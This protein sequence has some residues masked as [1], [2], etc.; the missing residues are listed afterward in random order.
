MSD[1]TALFLLWPELQEPPEPSV[2]DPYV[3]KTHESD[4]RPALIDLMNV[5][6]YDER[7]GVLNGRWLELC[8]PDGVFF[9]R[10]QQSGAVVATVSAVHNTRG[11]MFPF[12]GEVGMLAVHPEHRGRGLGSGLAASAINRLLSAGYRS[13]RVAVGP[14][15]LVAETGRADDNLFAIRTYLRLGFVPLLYSGAPE[16]RWRS[17]FQRI[18]HPFTPDQWPRLPSVAVRGREGATPAGVEP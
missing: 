4:D 13:I 10:H 7:S 16:A 15:P 9:A 5:A 18:E 2:P 8:L 1:V 3:I 11:G 14:W 6:G 12:G 17:I